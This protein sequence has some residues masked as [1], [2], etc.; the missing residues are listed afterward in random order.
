MERATDRDAEYGG[1]RE[2]I[3]EAA[4]R[5]FS[6]FG[7]ARTKIEAIAERAV[8]GKG[9]IY[10][11]FSGKD[12]VFRQM[13]MTFV[14]R[15]LDALL[16]RLEGPGSAGERLLS[17]VEAHLALWA[18]R[19]PPFSWHRR[20]FGFADDGLRAWLKEAKRRFLERLTATIA[21]GI[22]RG[23][24]RPVDARIA[25][26]WVFAALGAA[27]MEEVAEGP[28]VEER[29]QALLDLIRFGLWRAPAQ[30]AGAP[31]RASAGT[32]PTGS[33]ELPPDGPAGSAA[34]PADRPAAEKPRDEG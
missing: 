9:T 27:L 7:Y 16:A 14:G 23:E 6:E 32:G 20:D 25:A 1:K 29:R 8:V 28:A 15:H 17:M 19:P 24:F 31:E 22:E 3:L 5:V 33:A 11:Y 21:A 10:L 26:G 13:V 30:D 2:A 12:D 18:D 4:Y 34:D